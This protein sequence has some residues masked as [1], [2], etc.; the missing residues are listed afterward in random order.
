MTLASSVNGIN[1][2]TTADVAGLTVDGGVITDTYTGVLFAN[3]TTIVDGMA[4]DVSIAGTRF[5]H[6]TQKGT[7]SR[8][9]ISRPIP[10][11]VM[12]DVGQYGGG[13][14]FGA[15][16]LN[17]AGIDLNLKYANYSGIVID[18][19]TVHG[20][21]F[22]E[23]AR[24][25]ARQRRGD[26]GEGR[27]D[28]PSYSGTP[29]S[30]TGQLIIENGAIDGTST[31]I[32]AGEAGKSVAGPAVTIDNVTITDLRPGI[33]DNVTQS[34]MTVTGTSGADN[35]VAN[36]TTTG[37][38]N[39]DGG[40]GG[41]TIT[42]RSGNDTITGGDGSDTISAGSGTDTAVYNTAYAGHTVTWNGTTATVTGGTDTGA[43]GRQHHRG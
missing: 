10:N 15:K 25:L 20:C 6:I 28:A 30:Y 27:D 41:D 23:R 21:G 26:C 2:S 7:T 17:G 19:F 38:L 37:P 18:G 32:R 33:I 42:T 39:I 4:S 5:D 13:P 11:I 36:A 31:G 16:G 14:A 8:R 9:S 24:Q 29:T 35:L 22:F 34:V 1:K 12:N 40:L 3:S 43:D